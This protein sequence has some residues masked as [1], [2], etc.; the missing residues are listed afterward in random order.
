MVLSWTL[1]LLHFH[2]PLPHHHRCTDG[3]L[4][5]PSI[6]CTG[7]IVHIIHGC[8]DDILAILSH[9]WIDEF[10]IHVNLMHLNNLDILLLFAVIIWCSYMVLSLL[11]IAPIIIIM[12]NF[13][14][15]SL[16]SS[17]PF[18]SSSNG[19]YKHPQI[20][21]THWDTVTAYIQTANS[22]IVVRM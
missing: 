19:L 8:T 18:S 12:N 10:L 3:I 17:L 20:Y 7:G 5:T 11:P 21:Y 16:S 1:N 4:I 15:F 2:H 9:C 14:H 6:C 22:S 13:V